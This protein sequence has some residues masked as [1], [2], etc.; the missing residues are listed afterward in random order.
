MVRNHS[1]IDLCHSLVC[2]VLSFVYTQRSLARYLLRILGNRI[3]VQMDPS[4]IFSPKFYSLI[5]SNIGGDI[6]EVL[7]FVTCE[8]TFT[9]MGCAM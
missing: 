4:P 5:Q 6:G 8:Q 7:N 1:V 2:K 3:S 9:C